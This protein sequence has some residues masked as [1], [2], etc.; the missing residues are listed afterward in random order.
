M[1]NLYLII[2]LILSLN[3][4]VLGKTP[5]SFP[6]NIPN[7]KNISVG[8]NSLNLED[9]DKEKPTLVTRNSSSPVSRLGMLETK[10]TTLVTRNSSSLET[11]K[12]ETSEETINKANSTIDAI[13]NAGNYTSFLSTDDLLHLPIGIKSGNTKNEKD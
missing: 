10:K 13:N 9:I 12:E 11:Q 7:E 2:V 8:R 5:M 6:K 4:Q 3:L 1:K